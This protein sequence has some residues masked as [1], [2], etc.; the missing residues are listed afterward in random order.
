MGFTGYMD[1]GALQLD[2]VDGLK[3]LAPT[4]HFSMNI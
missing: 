3:L 4:G 2:S 1:M